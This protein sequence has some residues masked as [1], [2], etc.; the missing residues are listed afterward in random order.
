MGSNELRKLLQERD[1]FT[2]FLLSVDR[3]F[4]R[5]QLTSYERDFL[6]KSI[7]KGSSPKAYLGELNARISRLEL[8]PGKEPFRYKNQ[9]IASAVLVFI[10]LGMFFFFLDPSLTGLAGFEEQKEYV[11]K[12]GQAYDS[13]TTAEYYFN[14]IDVANNT[15]NLTSLKIKGSY[16]GIF[17][18]RLVKD[19][20]DEEGISQRLEYVIFDSGQKYEKGA[21]LITGLAIGDE[22]NITL[23]ET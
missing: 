5:R 2:K 15:N 19:Y 22:G 16:S 23:N 1:D 11:L 4:K 13:N 12:I 21:S 18:I 17:Q 14:I 6:I 20:T 8:R 10:F 9:V 3:K 7:T